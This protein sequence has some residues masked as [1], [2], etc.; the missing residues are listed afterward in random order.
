MSLKN[1]LFKEM[2]STFAI[3][4]QPNPAHGQPNPWTTLHLTDGPL[5]GLVPGALQSLL[6]C[7]AMEKHLLRFSWC[8]QLK[9]RPIG[10]CRR[11]KNGKSLTSLNGA[12][13]HSFPLQQ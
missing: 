12:H 2:F 8:S 4:D 11:S 1:K 3:V 10:G 9:H 7:G 5:S 13:F 6:I